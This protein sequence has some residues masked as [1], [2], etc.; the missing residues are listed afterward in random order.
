MEV[1]ACPKT[2]QKAVL[3]IYKFK[4]QPQ[5]WTQ[6]YVQLLLH[7]TNVLRLCDSEIPSR[8]YLSEE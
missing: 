6:L 8:V 2:E 7:L 5:F 1:Q 4:F 3:P